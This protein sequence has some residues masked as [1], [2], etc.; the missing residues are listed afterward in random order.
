VIESND[1]SSV[2]KKIKN[3]NQILFDSKS[4]S[5]NNLIV[6]MVKLDRK[7]TIMWSF[8]C[9]IATINFYEKLFGQ[10][11]IIRSAYETVA[12][13]AKG[14]TKMPVAK[15]AILSVHRL[16]SDSQDPVQIALVHAI[17]QALSCVHVQ[18]H[19]LSLIFYE[20]T[21]LVRLY[22]ITDFK[23]QVNQK[24]LFYQDRLDYRKNNKSIDSLRWA[25]FLNKY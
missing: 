3:G 16:A 10:N 8:D 6:D 9:V 2:Y 13:W 25:V 7:R 23:N 22:G 17:G 19:A 4:L 15:Q 11:M 20:L 5:I 12:S 1:F 18:R 14:E 24:I 21:A